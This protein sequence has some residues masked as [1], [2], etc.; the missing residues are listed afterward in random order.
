MRNKKRPQMRSFFIRE[1][2]AV[3]SRPAVSAYDNLRYSRWV[4]SRRFG[5][6]T[7]DKIGRPAHHTPEIRPQVKGCRVINAVHTRTGQDVIIII[8][9]RKAFLQQIRNNKFCGG[10]RDKPS[11]C[12]FRSVLFCGQS[13]TPVPTRLPINFAAP[14]PTQ[15]TK[16]HSERVLRLGIKCLKKQIFAV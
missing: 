12:P 7:S 2:L 16:K 8:P 4:S 9:R 14:V 5:L 6:P 15:T 3:G 10:R 11:D 13:G 1:N